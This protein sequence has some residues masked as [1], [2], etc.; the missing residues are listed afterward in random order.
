MLLG[1]RVFCLSG[2]S[3]HSPRREN[4][5]FFDTRKEG[6]GDSGVPH[7]S[8]RGGTSRRVHPGEMVE[9]WL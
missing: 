5:E 8:A 4:V 6:V 9:K 3:S 2:C 1:R 7:H